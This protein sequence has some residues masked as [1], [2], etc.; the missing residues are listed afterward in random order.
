M[1]QKTRTR[2][3]LCKR[4]AL[5]N[6]QVLALPTTPFTLVAAKVGRAWLPQFLAV[7]LNPRVAS[8]TNIDPTA[9][10]TLVV[11]VSACIT[12]DAAFSPTTVLAGADNVRSIQQIDVKVVDCTVAVLVNAP[13]VF[14]VTNGALGNFTGGD[15]GNVFQIKL[16]YSELTF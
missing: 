11:G 10:F 9:A 6:A 7:A 3:G 16:F 4:V 1:G 2:Y 14:N 15:V 8:V 5:T 13:I 12:L